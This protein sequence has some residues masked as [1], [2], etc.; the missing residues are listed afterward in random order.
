MA[1]QDATTVDAANAAAILQEGKDIAAAEA[2][3]AAMAAAVPKAVQSGLQEG[4]KDVAALG[5]QLGAPNAKA[6]IVAAAAP[7]AAVGIL[8][9]TPPKT[10]L[11]ERVPPTTMAS[12]R[13]ALAAPRP[14]AEEAKKKK[15]GTFKGAETPAGQGLT[16]VGEALRGGGE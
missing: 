7:L 15:K 3:K 6:E 8:A 4:G 11:P 13:E 5:T 16:A 12:P 9:P 10:Q 1:A 2:A 14:S